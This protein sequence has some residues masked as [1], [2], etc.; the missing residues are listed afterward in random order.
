MRTRGGLDDHPSPMNAIFRIRLIILGKSPGIVQ[1]SLNSLPPI[2]EEFVA[3]LLY[4]Q[5]DIQIMCTEKPPKSVGCVESES[6]LSSASSNFNFNSVEEADGQRYL[7]GWITRKFKTKYPWLGN[8]TY[9]D[10]PSSGQS[11]D[12]IRSLSHGGLMVPSSLWQYQSKILEQRF[13]KCHKDGEFRYKKTVSKRLSQ[14]CTRKYPEI[15]PE[16]I[17]AYIKQRSIIRMRVLN[18]KLEQEK[19]RKRKAPFVDKNSG[20]TK[21]F[22]KIIN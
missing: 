3:P 9:I 17:R 11:T 14:F 16:V 4:R 18:T 5:S 6:D 21:K 12:M 19:K 22:K 20:R 1:S 7:A 15:P 8:Y 10:G 2:E 13:L